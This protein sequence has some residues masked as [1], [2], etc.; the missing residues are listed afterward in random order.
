MNT[1][2]DIQELLLQAMD[3][4]A[5]SAIKEDKKDSDIT[6]WTCKIV[7]DTNRKSGEYKVTDDNV[8]FYAY[9]QYTEYKKDE[10][11]AV[12]I[13]KGDFNN[14]KYIVQKVSADGT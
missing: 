9:S 13:P 11:V 3:I 14:T 1:T 10:H 8:T 12:V 6:L 2:N 5:N 7:D 4:I